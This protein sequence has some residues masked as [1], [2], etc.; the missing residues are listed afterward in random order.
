MATASLAYP[1]VAKPDIGCNGTGVRLIADQAALRRY[2]TDFPADAAIVLQ[3]FVPYEGEAGLFYIRRPGETNGR[4][5]SLTLK[6]APAVTGDGRSTLRAL[7]LADPRARAIRRFFIPRLGARLDA[8]PRAGERVPLVFV[9]NHCKGSTFRDACA[10][11]TPAMTARIDAIA[12]AMPE[13]HFGR[14]DVRYRSLAALKRG[15]DFSVIEINGVGSEATHVWDP[16]GRL[17]PAWRDQFFHY[18][19]AFEIGR[20]NIARGF[21]PSGLRAM[22]S[23]WRVQTR[24]LAAYPTHD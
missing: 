13:F 23:R 5:T 17:L 9:G 1:I 19:A 6:E 15:E 8:V 20:A 2:L 12:R 11:I 22:F 18:R 4:L 7:I 3:A 14:F 21:R 10:D 24:L 16:R